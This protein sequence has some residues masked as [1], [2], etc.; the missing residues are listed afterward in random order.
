VLLVVSIFGSVVD[1]KVFINIMGFKE[2]V[3]KCCNFNLE[4]KVFPI[5]PVFELRDDFGV[6]DTK[7]WVFRAKSLFFRA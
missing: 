4:K 6:F 3:S 1:F 5:A 7:I 2:I